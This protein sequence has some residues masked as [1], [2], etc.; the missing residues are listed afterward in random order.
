[1]NFQ[2]VS[3]VYTNFMYFGFF[4]VLDVAC[5]YFAISLYRCCQLK[6]GVLFH[7]MHFWNSVW[8]LCIIKFMCKKQFT[9]INCPILFASNIVAFFAKKTKII[10][11]LFICC[12]NSHT[13]T[14]KNTKNTSVNFRFLLSYFHWKE[15]LTIM[16]LIFCFKIIMIQFFLLLVVLLLLLLF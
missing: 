14:K 15:S 5:L 12:F 7:A 8:P 3:T 1:M 10:Q 11:F 9:S 16:R 13:Q 4:C 2:Q 6:K